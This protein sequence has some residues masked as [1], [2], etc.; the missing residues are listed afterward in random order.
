MRWGRLGAAAEALGRGSEVCWSTGVVESSGIKM[1]ERE[2]WLSAK[3]LISG[4]QFL[5]VPS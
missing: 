1:R 2:G 4:G 5:K 3:V